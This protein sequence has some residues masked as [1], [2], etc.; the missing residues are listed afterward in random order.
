MQRVF[1]Q[2]WDIADKSG[3][4]GIVQKESSYCQ[5][6]LKGGESS[7]RVLLC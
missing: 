7:K 4:L 3:Q 5:L 6:C 2:K 1:L